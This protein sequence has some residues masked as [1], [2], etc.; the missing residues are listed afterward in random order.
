M[1]SAIKLIRRILNSINDKVQADESQP[2]E[3]MILLSEFIDAHAA[4][5]QLSKIE[6]YLQEFEE[7]LEISIVVSF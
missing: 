2:N 5:K 6:N 7:A 3:S 1:I 4:A